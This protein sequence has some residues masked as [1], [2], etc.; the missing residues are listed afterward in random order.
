VSVGFSSVVQALLRD[1]DGDGDGDGDSPP[2]RLFLDSDFS[3]CPLS[4]FRVAA[5]V[6]RRAQGALHSHAVSAARSF[7]GR[8]FNGA[9]NPSI[10][11]AFLFVAQFPAIFE[12]PPAQLLRCLGTLKLRFD[13]V[14][15]LLQSDA[16]GRPLPPLSPLLYQKVAGA[17]AKHA[18]AFMLLWRYAATKDGAALVL[19][20][21]GG[22]L[23]R[24]SVPADYVFWTLKAVEPHFPEKVALLHSRTAVQLYVKVLGC[25]DAKLKPLQ[26]DALN[27]L[28]KVDFDRESV[29]NL[30]FARF[31]SGVTQL[32]LGDKDCRD[33]VTS[34]I[35]RAARTGDADLLEDISEFTIYLFLGSN[36]HGYRIMVVLFEACVR[37]GADEGALKKRFKKSGPVQILLEIDEA[38]VAENAKGDYR[39]L[40]QIFSAEP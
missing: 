5:D 29:A 2:I 30:V 39:S 15:Y 7:I 40:I 32:A 18:P 1:L 3:A 25:R 14:N 26:V 31:F 28:K 6:L 19:K 36:Q 12:V 17:G 38:E 20:H 35:L 37:N 4:F 23:L 24:E 16:L 9:S 22:R 10:H 8:I 27:T 33:R 21:A 34:I 13:A 11:A